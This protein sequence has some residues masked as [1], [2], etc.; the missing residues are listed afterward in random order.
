[1]RI[2]FSP[3]VRAWLGLATMVGA[4][5]EYRFNAGAAAW[6][7]GLAH[8]LLGPSGDGH[9]EELGRSYRWVRLEVSLL[10]AAGAALL[11]SAVVAVLA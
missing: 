9:R 5:L 7:C 11:L 4:W 1:M 2:A 8:A 3:A 10:G 6:Y